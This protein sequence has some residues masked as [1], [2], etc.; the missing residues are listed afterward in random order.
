MEL[1]QIFGEVGIAAIFSFMNK[2]WF[3]LHFRNKINRL[4]SIRI[5]NKLNNIIL[6]KLN[7]LTYNHMETNKILK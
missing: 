5:I 6:N 3:M 7:I 2:I 4:V 1:I